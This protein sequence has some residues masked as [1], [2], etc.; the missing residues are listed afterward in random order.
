MSMSALETTP[1]R[2]TLSTISSFAITVGRMQDLIL[3][4]VAAFLLLLLCHWNPHTA[5][6]I[7]LGLKIVGMYTKS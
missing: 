7:W 5:G 4:R 3:L 6:S 2:S 1:S